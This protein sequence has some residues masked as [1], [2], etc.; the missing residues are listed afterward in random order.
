MSHIEAE[1]NR[2]SGPPRA[3]KTAKV[4]FLPKL[5]RIAEFLVSQGITTVGNMLY[6]F[7]CIRLLPVGEYAKF[8]VVFSI[9]ASLMILLD[10]GIS[11]TFIPLVGERI[12][13]RQLI[14]DYLASLRQ[15]AHWLFAIAAPIAIVAYPFLVRNRHWSWQTV[16]AMVIIVLVSAWFARVG[17]AYGAVLILRR[18]RRRWYRAQ[19]FTSFGAL[20]L[21][22]V[23]V[24]FHWLGAFVTILVSV[25]RIIALA[26]IYYV[27]ARKL[28]GVRGVPSREKRTAV[29]Q[30]SLPAIPSVIYYAL[31]G[32]I[33]V[34]LIT[35]FGRTAAV[36][37]VGALSRLGQIFALLTPINGLLVEPYFAKLP[38][39]HLK[40]HYL[41]AV[42][43]AGACGVGMVTLAHIFPGPFLWVL[44]PKYA[45][46]HAEVG[47][48]I[49]SGAIS[50]VAGMMATINGSRR[51]I[52]YSLVLADTIVTLILQAVYI[53]RVDLSTVKAVLWFNIFTMGPTV[54]IGV[55]TAFYGFARGGRK[56][57]ESHNVQQSTEIADI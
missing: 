34:F 19:M 42:A 9:Q 29:V 39:E 10:V 43:G 37:S 2:R 1:E 55:I 14:A 17:S 8:V 5:R 4:F 31:G 18:D 20:A 36:A 48:V 38:R 12:E 23:F 50:L 11:G 47:L 7:L 41:M 27:R 40:S 44:G 45:G 53:W 49:L 21:L 15:I 57:V 26:L 51:F 46:L 30:L 25:G 32:Q 3:V 22:G 56:I 52:Y 6:G 35:Y 24:L 28:L 13:D 54:A 33:S 16:T